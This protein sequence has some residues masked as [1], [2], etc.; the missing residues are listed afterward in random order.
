LSVIQSVIRKKRDI[1]LVLLLRAILMNV[2]T[3][4]NIKYSEAVEVLLSDLPEIS[5][6]YKQEQSKWSSESIPPHV[7]YGSIFSDFLRRVVVEDT[8]D[9]GHSRS[10]II[11]R[12][13]QLIEE[14][15]ES[16]DFETRCIVYASIL[17]SLLGQDKEDWRRFAP[18]FGKQ[19]LE[20]ALK[21][22]ERW[23][24][25]SK[26]EGDNR[27]TATEQGAAPDCLRCGRR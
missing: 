14:L 18:Y 16:D 6:A 5:D 3:T 4:R 8:R 26:N 12:S 20:M 10:D 23:G 19:T 24:Y 27:L 9:S 11:R 22:A 1:V 2:K 17:E 13:F 25:L 21:L 15:V 7:V